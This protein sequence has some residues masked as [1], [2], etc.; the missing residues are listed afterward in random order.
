M[1]IVD[2][3]GGRMCSRDAGEHSRRFEGRHALELLRLFEKCKRSSEWHP[4][5]YVSTLQSSGFVA[6]YKRCVGRGRCREDMLR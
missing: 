2:M 5:A 6:H 3:E 1:H 4:I